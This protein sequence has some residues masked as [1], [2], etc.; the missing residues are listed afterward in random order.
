MAGEVS[1]PPLTGGTGTGVAAEA[2]E[3]VPTAHRPGRF[4]RL[5]H[6]TLPGCWGAVVFAALSLTPS[7]LPRGG[8]IQGLVCGITAAIGYGLGVLVA[9]LWRAY[10]DRDVRVPKPSSWRAFLIIAGV[11]LVVLFALGQYWQHEIRALMGV[12]EYNVALVVAS[13]FVAVFFFALFLAL[14]RGIRRVYHLV[15]KLLAR[16]FGRRAAAATG[17]VLVSVTVFFLV[18]GVLLDGLVS[19]MD[20]AFSV[21]NGITE[22]GVAQP[23]TGLRS[24]GPGS[25][26]PWDSLGREGRTFA[27]SGPAASDIATI[28]HHPAQEPIRIYAGLDSADDAEQR[29]AL[30][31][32]DLQRAGGFQRANLLVLT[33]TGSGWVDPALVAPFEYLSGGDEATVAMQYSYLPSWLSFLVDQTKAREAGRALFDAVYD[34]WSKL[35]ANQRPKLFVGG[36]SLGTFGGETAFSG[37]YDLSNRT[38]GTVFAGP[39]NFNTLFR[40][41]SDHREPGSPEIQPVFK[42]GRTVRFATDAGSSVPPVGQPWDGTRVLY[43]M[44]PSDPIVWWTPHLL[45][46]EPDWIGEAP[47]K[48]VL[49]QMFWMPLVTFWQVSA[50][51][52]FSTGVPPGHGHKY[53]TE[54]V[55]GWYAVMRPSGFTPADLTALRT[56]ISALE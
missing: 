56:A 50:D 34:R 18:S 26:V 41:F 24:G 14:S 9:W 44:H 19:V 3:T 31:V 22:E 20:E 21:R 27:G 46:T 48:D 23:A 7:L 40:E 45:F 17:W 43:L 15:A 42:D 12:T 37:E 13:P 2:T 53:T 39:P 36:E 29:A 5:L 30:A 6:L 54:Y 49:P 25:L 55:D 10:A 4:R 51:L 35:P 8:F 52:P 28:V 16:H 33:T 11:L 32:S 47:G 1:D 38:A